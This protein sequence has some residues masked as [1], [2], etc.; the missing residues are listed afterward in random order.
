MKSIFSQKYFMLIS[1]SFLLIFNTASYSNVK[2]NFAAK[3]ISSVVKDTLI[4]Q[5]K[6][7]GLDY[8]YNDE[9]HKNKS[10]REVQY[11][12]IWED[13][14]NSGY[15]KVGALIKNLGAKLGELH[16]APSLRNLKKFSIYIIVDPD[17]PAENPHPN[18]IEEPAIKNIV[19]WVKE[20]GILMLLGNDK[21]NAE[22]KHLNMLAE[23]FGIHFNENSINDVVNDNFDQGKF[24]NLPDEPIF[25]GVKEIYMKEI[26]TLKLHTPAKSLL[27]DSGNVII[28]YSKFG[29]GGVFAVGDPWFYNEYIDNHKLPK[30]F[31]NYKATDN[32]FKWL[33]GKANKEGNN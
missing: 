20:G 28:A 15:S 25:K 3:N 21:G 9:W 5:G 2:K 29:K 1:I 16:K 33:L 14:A 24:I 12:Y 4:G 18:Y 6:V 11:H 8:F 30:R 22:F 31:Q 23:N 27:T 17:I 7:V 13:T 26:S 19:K 10:G 32:L